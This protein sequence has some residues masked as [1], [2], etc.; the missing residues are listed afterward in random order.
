MKLLTLIDWF[1]PQVVMDDITAFS[2]ARTI[3]G[4]SLFF[5]FFILISSFRGFSS[6]NPFIGVMML[7]VGF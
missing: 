6:E 7:V 5:A 3:T 2:K 1:I 4:M